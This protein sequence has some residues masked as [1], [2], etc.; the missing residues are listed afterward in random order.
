VV[1]EHLAGS[2]GLEPV[3][4]LGVSE[5]RILT[6]DGGGIKGVFAASFLAEIENSLGEPLVDHFDLIAGTSTGGIIA[7]GLGLGLS[8]Q[9]ILD[10]YEAKSPVVFQGGRRKMLRRVFAAKY[11]GVPLKS[12][13]ESVFGNRLLGESK[14]RL[15]IPSLNLETGEVHVFKTAHHERFVRD[16]KERAVDV[17][18]ATAAAPTYFPT[19]RL[20]A[21]TPLIDGG[22][23][24][25]NPMG[26]AAVEALGVLELR[27]GTIKL[28]GVG[29]TESPLDTYDRSR[30]GL[31]INYWA[32]RLA[33]IFMAGQSS[34][35]LGT[36]QVLLGHD[37]VYR[38]SPT[39]SGGR[40]KLD[41]VDGIKSL[42][43]LGSSEA[44]KEY[45]KVQ[46]MFLTSK[47]PEFSPYREVQP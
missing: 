8:A 16:Y 32:S 13:L 19:H 46:S 28:L 30:G 6:L 9:D 12:A 11:Q 43:G 45:P 22:M 20:S 39:V 25:N 38:V 14:T 41:G 47:R 7:L 18:L 42:R 2:G 3:S 24:A 10:F 27:K 35:S 31:G 26:T 17:A 1:G 36:A 21:G 5:F 37:N 23:W 44:R 4:D 40:Y 29:C 33:S 15:V 34:S